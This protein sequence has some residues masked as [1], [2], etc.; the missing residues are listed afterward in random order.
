VAPAIAQKGAG[1]KGGSPADIAK[2]RDEV[3]R[4]RSE[5]DAALKDIR[6]LKEALAGKLPVR[7]D[8]GP[9]FQGRSAARWLEQYKDADPK[10]RAEAVHALG[11]IAPKKKEL[12]PFLI[13]AMKTDD[14]PKV[15]ASAEAA[16]AGLGAEIIP[17]MI[18]LV[19]DKESLTARQGAVSVLGRIGPSAK[20]AVPVLIDALKDKDLPLRHRAVLALTKIGPDARA[21]VPPLVEMFAVTFQ[22]AKVA[23]EGEKTALKVKGG[24]FREERLGKG[25]M[26]RRVVEALLAIDPDPAGHVQARVALMNR[27]ITSDQALVPIFE[28]IQQALAERYPRGKK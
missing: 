9:L 14:D 16:L 17:R 15:R 3:A 6:D 25:S 2:L 28:E 12:A 27:M 11:F 8:E 4:L 24:P 13:G 20:A 18:D 7:P 22:E 1:G 19:Q 5:L 26:P 10:F 21:A 23:I